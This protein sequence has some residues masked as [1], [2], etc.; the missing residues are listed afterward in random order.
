MKEVWLVLHNCD[1]DCYG[2]HEILGAYGTEEK[3]DEACATAKEVVLASAKI[4]VQKWE[5]K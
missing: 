1:F 4:Q 3:A 5:V 2:G